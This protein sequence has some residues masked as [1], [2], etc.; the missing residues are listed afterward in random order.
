MTAEVRRR[1]RRVFAIAL[2]VLLWIVSAGPAAA[3]VIPSIESKQIPIL[4]FRTNPPCP[5]LTDAMRSSLAEAA[6]D[7]TLAPWQRE[8]MREL[9][10]GQA[11][12]DPSGSPGGI[13]GFP[14]NAHLNSADGVWAEVPSFVRR[15]GC[16][17]VYAPVRDRMVIFGGKRGGTYIN[18][19]WAL[20]FVGSPSWSKLMPSGTAPSGRYRLSAIYDP[21][22][23]RMVVFGGYRGV[24][25]P[26]TPGRSR[27]LGIRLGHS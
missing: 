2:V 5:Q 1:G 20:S 26:M 12:G 23:D 22:R 6:R 15:H 7:S 18:E 3:L 16:I 8:Y 11:L 14:E 25:L 13:D 21:V 27:S 10:Q 24:T 17:A 4:T 19:T 9:S